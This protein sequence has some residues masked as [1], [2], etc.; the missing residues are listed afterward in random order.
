ME[1]LLGTIADYFARVGVAALKLEESLSVGETIHVKGHTTDVTQVVESMQIE[2]NAVASA[3]KGEDVGIKLNTRA[4]HG[5][6]IF[7]VVA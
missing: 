5:D 2:H 3:K 4:H 6:K 1:I 7:K